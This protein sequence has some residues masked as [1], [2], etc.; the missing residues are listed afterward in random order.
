M[1]KAKYD[2][3][4]LVELLQD[5]SDNVSPDQAECSLTY[6]EATAWASGVSRGLNRAIELLASGDYA[7]A[8]ESVVRDAYNEGFIEGMNE[9]RSGGRSWMDSAT[10]RRLLS[11][12]ADSP[13]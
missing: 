4:R 1:S 6:N 8:V 7:S 11:T 12:R 10:R 5:E 3:G 13:R 9:F 2:L